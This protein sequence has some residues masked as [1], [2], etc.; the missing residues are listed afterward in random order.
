MAAFA[1]TPTF[2]AA[3]LGSNV[4]TAV[5]AGTLSRRTEADRN[6]LDQ[7][8]AAWSEVHKLKAEAEQQRREVD[9]LRLEHEALRVQYEGL[10]A[11]HDTLRAAYE[12]LRVD[13]EHLNGMSIR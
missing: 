3:M 5:V 2:M 8:K 7:V 6:L 4:L 10:K 12:A 11:Q 13:I 1:D 9:L